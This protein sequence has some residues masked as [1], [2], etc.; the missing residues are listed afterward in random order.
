LEVGGQGRGLVLRSRLRLEYAVDFGEIEFGSV[1]GN[2]SR[3]EFGSVVGNRSRLEFGSV[4]GMRLRRARQCGRYA[5]EAREA[6]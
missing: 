5:L 4:V 1:V 2:R 3:L 6:V